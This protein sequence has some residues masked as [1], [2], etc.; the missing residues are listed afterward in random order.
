MASLREF[1]AAEAEKLHGEQIEAR[2]KREEWIA[3]VRRLLDQIKGWLGEADTKG[4][5][6]ID[7][8]PLRLSEQGMGTYEIPALT[9]GMG[10][11]EVRIKPVARHVMA[12][13]RATTMLQILR[14][15]GRVDMTNGL[16]RYLIFRVGREPDRWTIVE[17]NGP[18]VETFD[19]TSFESA[20][21]SLLE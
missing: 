16:D 11:R 21:K 12:P 14:A 10:A 18:S 13:L 8:S 19:Q 15:H 17:Q 6:S 9:I 7:E 2:G 1:L 5:L 20:F 4:I 3:S